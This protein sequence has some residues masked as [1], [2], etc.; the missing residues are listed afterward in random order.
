MDDRRKNEKML[1]KLVAVVKTLKKF[2][3]LLSIILPGEQQHD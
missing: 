2:K 1:D 3:I